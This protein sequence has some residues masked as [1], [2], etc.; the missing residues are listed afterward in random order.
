MLTKFEKELYGT[1]VGMVFFITIFILLFSTSFIDLN[2]A[3]K[4]SGKVEEIFLTRNN[5]KASRS[6]PLEKVAIKVDGVNQFLCYYKLTDNYKHI[7]SDIK[8]GDFITVYYK[9]NYQEYNLELYQLIKN[10]RVIIDKSNH[11]NSQRIGSIL[12]LILG[13]GG[14]GFIMYSK[15]KF[16]IEYSKVNKKRINT[17]PKN[18]KFID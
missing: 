3:T 8:V 17:N 9:P 14:L 1:A 11:E 16:R 18:E 5:N 10:K 4:K 6:L 2:Q 7:M 15:I 12:L 13:V